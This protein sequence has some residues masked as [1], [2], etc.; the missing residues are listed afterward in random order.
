[1]YL[2][3][4]TSASVGTLIYEIDDYSGDIN[5]GET[6][7]SAAKLN[8]E[9]TNVEDIDVTKITFKQR[10]S[11]DPVDFSNEALYMSGMQ[12][13]DNPTWDG[14]FRHWF[15][16]VFAVATASEFS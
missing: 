10:G 6:G 2:R 5:V 12:I 8:L 1:M 3:Q 9:A 14:D 11:A 4:T 16:K 13:A 15:R 7:I